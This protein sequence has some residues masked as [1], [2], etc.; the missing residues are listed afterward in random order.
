MAIFSALFDRVIAVTDHRMAPSTYGLHVKGE[1][2]A[3]RLRE[4]DSHVQRETPSRRCELAGHE[5]V[6]EVAPSMAQPP[7]GL[8]FGN[9]KNKSG[10]SVT[11]ASC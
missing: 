3:S 10:S 6:K 4:L 2:N 7:G 9:W 11:A 1:Q 5:P 8:K